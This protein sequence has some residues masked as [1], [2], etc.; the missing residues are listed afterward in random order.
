MFKGYT[1]FSQLTNVC[2][3]VCAHV[4]HMLC[5]LVVPMGLETLK[6]SYTSN[7]KVPLKHPMP[8]IH[9]QNI[10]VLWLLVQHS[11]S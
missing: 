10:F 8:K 7:E 1:T 6:L 9:H 11:L 2:F 4:V 5:T 3:I